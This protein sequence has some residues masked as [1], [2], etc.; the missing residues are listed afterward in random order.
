[1][2]PE[3]CRECILSTVPFETL[4]SLG[5]IK[6]KFT[7]REQVGYRFIDSRCYVRTCDRKKK[8]G[9]EEIW[10]NP[11]G[12]KRCEIFWKNGKKDG[13]ETGWYEN[14]NKRYETNWKNGWR[15]GVETLWKRDG[16]QQSQ[17]IW[18]NGIIY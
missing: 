14:G 10:N 11:G 15:D 1:M 18:K 2:F 6:V 5:L 9:L 4:V 7:K 12:W 3:D 17:T 13:R 8:E 16:E